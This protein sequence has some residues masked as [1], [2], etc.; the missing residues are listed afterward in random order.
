MD[1]TYTLFDTLRTF[2][3]LRRQNRQEY[4]NFMK[5][6]ERFKGSEGYEKDK[7]T[8]AQ[9][10]QQ[11]DDAARKTATAK[12]DECIKQMRENIGKRAISAPTAEM[13]NILQILN[14][15]T[16]M[17][18]PML[19]AAARAMNGN[20]LCLS[21][22]NDIAAKHEQKT[23]LNPRTA[24]PGESPKKF[25]SFPDYMQYATDLGGDKASRYIDNVVSSCREIL[26]SPVKSFL[27]DNAQRQERMYGTKYDIDDLPQR[28]ELVSER[29]FF[30]DIVPEND[31]AGF[32]QAVNGKEARKE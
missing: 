27:L 13:V 21:A 19:D 20:S 14:M 5:Q 6:H 10:R 25:V 18:R 28:G 1:I 7:A 8:A 26:K 31:Y 9:K 15:K 17:T 4:L 29:G 11:A 22:L 2:D 24:K 23:G 16:S 32:M 12:I 3:N 30:G